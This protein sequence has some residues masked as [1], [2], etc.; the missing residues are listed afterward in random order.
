MGGG[1]HEVR[2]GRRKVD[3]ILS[4][5][6]A[7]NIALRAF[8]GPCERESDR[9][10]DFRT[11]NA[12]RISAA[13]ADQSV[14]G[15]ANLAR[16]VSDATADFADLKRFPDDVTKRI[17]VIT[18]GD[19]CPGDALRR[20][21]EHLRTLGRER[22]FALDFRFVGVA[23]PVE[24]RLELEEI[25]RELQAGQ[26]LYADDEEQ[27]AVALRRVAITEP[28][29]ESIG[30]VR[31]FV[32]ASVEHLNAV[33]DA[34]FDERDR[35]R[36]EEILGRAQQTVGHRRERFD[37]LAKKHGRPEFK[38]L[39]RLARTNLSLQNELLGWAADSLDLADREEASDRRP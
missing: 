35:E 15:Q 27:L 3:E 18:G 19:T 24:E 33:A 6:S 13:L 31:T 38:E 14:G 32:D 20:I 12:G 39:Y 30:A 29:L 8:G 5:E 1:N 26:P 16:A 10:V 25:S 36:A 7:T 17:V 37:R 22:G 28:L 11:N 4:V 34:I 23:V 2:G 9:L 21:R